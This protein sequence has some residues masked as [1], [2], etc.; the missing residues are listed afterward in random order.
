M[1]VLADETQIAELL[2]RLVAQA[3][4]LMRRNPGPWAIKVLVQARPA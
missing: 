4:D 1:K 2:D 3:T